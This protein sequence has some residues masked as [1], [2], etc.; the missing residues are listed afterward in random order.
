MVQLFVGW[1]VYNA[2]AAAHAADADAV[3]DA[4][5]GNLH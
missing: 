3:A 4:D 1:D 5:A 2:A